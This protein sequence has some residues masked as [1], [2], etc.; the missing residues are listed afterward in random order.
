VESTAGVTPVSVDAVPDDGTTPGARREALVRRVRV[1]WGRRTWHDGV[2]VLMVLAFTAVFGALGIARHRGLLTHA[3]DAGQMIQAFWTIRHGGDVNTVTGLPFLGDHARFVLY[4]LA[5]LGLPAQAL[6]V[7][8][9]FTLALGAVPVYLLTA[10]RAPRWAALTAAALFLAY[11]SLQWTA[12][13]DLHPEV[14]ATTLLLFAFWAV[15]GRRHVAYAVTVLLALACREDA[16]VAVG[17]MGLLLVLERRWRVGLLTIGGAVGGLVVATLAQRAAN[18]W[19]LSVLEERFGYLGSTPGEVAARLAQPAETFAGLHLGLNGWLM[20]LG[21]LLPAAP[22]FLARWTRLLPA[23]PL[24]VLSLLSTL[25]MQKT[26]YF[27][28]GFLPTVFIFI[29]VSDGMVRL[30]G[31][32]PR[33]RAVVAP[34]VAAVVAVT[35]VVGSPFTDLGY[36]GP[37]A[38]GKPATVQDQLART[39]TPEFR[40]DAR[41]VLAQVGEGSVSASANLLPQLAERSEVYMFPNPFYPAWNGRYLT[42]WPGRS[43]RPTIP[44]DPPRWVVVDLVHTGPEPPEVREEL[45][46]LLPE[47][48]RLVSET[49]TVQLWE[50]R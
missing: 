29:A 38:W 39:F 41:D 50:E 31:L 34:V 35:V 27:H 3:F 43:V 13:F 23:L 21:F 19:G 5:L 22:M 14:M 28:Y 40:A 37:H 36:R 8:Q 49:P 30:A 15:D 45:L 33:A 42:S 10:R 12:L 18:P 4:P 1:W 7:A 6:F 17:L 16:S 48:Y 32:R 9:S 26:I 2:L 24:L 20:V 11:P 44:P 25:P 47:A 46:D